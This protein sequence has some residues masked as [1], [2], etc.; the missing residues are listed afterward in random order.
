MGYILGSKMS[1][2][3]CQMGQ[4]IRIGHITRGGR[5]WPIDPPVAP[6]NHDC[7]KHY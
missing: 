6:S 4:Q 7:C 3:V 2:V 1:L 5:L